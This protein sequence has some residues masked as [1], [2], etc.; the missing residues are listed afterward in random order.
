[1]TR[2]HSV[3]TTAANWRDYLREELRDLL[4]HSFGQ[5]IS[6]FTRT[7]DHPALAELNAASQAGHHI[8]VYTWAA[9]KTGAWSPS[10]D[11]QLMGSM[12]QIPFQSLVW[13][14]GQRCVYHA[15]GEVVFVNGDPEILEMV[16]EII[17]F[18][19]KSGAPNALRAI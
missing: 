8:R 7:G 19:R 17:A 9:P 1:M 2:L 6:V 5:E 16:G 12:Y 10:V 14:D 13:I 4:L 11:V 3:S 15:A 18:V